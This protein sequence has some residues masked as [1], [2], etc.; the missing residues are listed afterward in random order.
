MKTDVKI[1]KYVWFGKVD[2]IQKMFDNFKNFSIWFQVC[3]NLH[4]NSILVMA[5]SKSKGWTLSNNDNISKAKLNIA[6]KFR[7][8]Y[9]NKYINKSTHFINSYSTL[10]KSMNENFLIYLFQD[11]L[12][13]RIFNLHSKTMPN[14]PLINNPKMNR[15]R[16]CNL[17]VKIININRTNV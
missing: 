10:F 2:H 16:K 15:M 6:N 7:Q 1:L 13:Y 11:Y 9:I 17:K 14:R 12:K 5:Y 3:L 8:T 4:R